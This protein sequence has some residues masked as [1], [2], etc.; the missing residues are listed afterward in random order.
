MD[1]K[2]SFLQTH[3]RGLQR[4]GA[5]L[6]AILVWQ[7]AAMG[8]GHQLLVPS[9]LS[10]LQRLALIWMEDGFWSTI[11]FTFRKIVAGFL[12]G[13]GLGLGLGALAGRFPL[14]EILFR[15][16]AV[17]V[18]SVPVASFIV[19]CLIWMSSARLSIFISFL[20]VLPI[21]YTNVLQSIRS[22]DRQMLEAVKIFRLSW[23]KRVLYLWLPQMK[24][25]LLSACTVGLGISWKAGIAAEIIGI[26][27]GSIG[28][29]FYDAK[30]Y[31]NTTDLFTWTIIVV[32][33][34]V[35]FE[36]GFLA[37]LKWFYR[38]LEKL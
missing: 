16:W 31:F 29:M 20:M 32:V 34:S 23:R 5:V 33:V 12:L 2:A 17:M 3:K 13:L 15:P 11:W 4:V 6:L 24:P 35:L 10:V 36:K 25:Y 38:R 26:P 18:K 7:V 21:V 27:S 37:L 8:V 22:V 28:Q 30:V 14:F 19:I 1:R 9:P